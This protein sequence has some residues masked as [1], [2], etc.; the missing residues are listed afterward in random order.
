MNAPKIDLS[1][2]YLEMVR[3]I[4]KSEIPDVLVW[5]FGS[6]ANQTAKPYSD[7]DC[8]LVAEKPLSEQKLSRLKECLACSNLPFA[9]DLVEWQTISPEFRR[10]I[11]SNY[12]SLI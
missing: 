6:R 4:F 12:V 7:L 10:I 2:R 5:V 9:V 3:E 8:V 11:K 1:P